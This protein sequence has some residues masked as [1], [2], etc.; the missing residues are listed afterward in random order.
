MN[1]KSAVSRHEKTASFWSRRSKWRPMWL[2]VACLGLQFAALGLDL[3]LPSEYA[4][5]TL[6]IGATLL[7]FWL[8]W[9][10][11]ILGIAVVG[12]FFSIL[13]YVMSPGSPAYGSD[14]TIANRIVA[15]LVIWWASA[16]A[17]AHNRYRSALEQ[18]ETR[19]H[20]NEARIRSIL[21]T[22]PDA[23]VTID[24]FGSIETFSAS[25]EL[26]FGYSSQEVIGQN[27][28]I[29]MTFPHREAHDGY[30]ESYRRT[31]VRRIIGIGRV[32]N[33]RRKDGT[34][35]PL[36]LAVGEARDGGARIFTGFMRDLTARQ[37]VEQE[38]RHAQKMEAVGQL[39]G[40]VSHDFNNLLTVILGNLEMLEARLTEPGHLELVREARETAEH[41][42][43]LTERLLAFGR[44]QPL[45]PALTDVAE[46][47][48][49]LSPLLRRTLGETVEIH[50]RASSQVSK[51]MVDPGQLQ[52]A[53]LN[54]ALNARDAMP[55][56]GRLTVSA[57][58]A[59]IDPDY[60]VQ[61]VD[62]RP[63]SYVV[64]A[65]SDTGT[66][67]TKEVL[68]RAFDPFFTT[69]EVGVGS[70]LGLSMVYGF[71]KQSNGHAQIYSEVGQGTTVR[72]YLPQV[73]EPAEGEGSNATVKPAAALQAHDE[74]I[75]VVED[76]PRVRRLTVRRLREL[77][78]KIHEAANGSA[79]LEIL[80]LNT[81]ID[82]VFTDIVMP[83][84]MSGAD[85]GRAVRQR[86]PRMKILYTSGYADHDIIKNDEMAG[87]E[88]LRK[89]YPAAELARS[90]REILD[91]PG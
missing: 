37:R 4:V 33:G 32:V 72:L 80:A 11:A 61:Q 43:Q 66:G 12:S 48:D 81:D 45:Q 55:N 58:N 49:G 87:A 59:T 26:L 53:I 42:A 57:E 40:G 60:A 31:G 51:V 20:V 83:G 84:G 35:F 74:T 52:T 2:F 6:Y 78:Y 68:E 54:L 56:G 47:L 21:E 70:G 79:A 63:G 5:A 46:L 9:P 30:L 89:P 25:A 27:V 73:E 8:P 86:W 7:A 82:L 18:S 34:I 14:E 90:V 88:W 29:L 22:V 38:L 67:M 15:V 85:L 28:N 24:E 23:L 36:E 65:V 19:L 17:I 10:R 39:T 41:G 1:D 71:V 64:L 75:L 16:L 76:E 62:V 44:R 91:A 3:S 13:G 77:G 69:K 50:T